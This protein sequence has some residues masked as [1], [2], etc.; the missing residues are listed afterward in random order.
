MGFALADEAAR[1]GAEVVLVAGPTSVAPPPVSELVRVRSAR[2]MHAAVMARASADATS[3]SWPRPSP[4]T[5]PLPAPRPRRSKSAATCPLALERT[6]DI[7]AELGAR[8]GERAI[9]RC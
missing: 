8:R 3:S 5:R 4:T 1:R 2:E 7:L 9:A 6:P